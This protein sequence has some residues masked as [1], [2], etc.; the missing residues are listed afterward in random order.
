[1][2]NNLSAILDKAQVYSD[3]KKIEST[4]LLNSR[5]AA[6]QFNLTRQV[7]TTCD[8]A[9]AYASKLTEKQAP[10]NPDT[11]TTIAELK[12]RIQSTI[13]FLN[14]IKPEDFKGWESRKITNPR[15]EGKYLPANEYALQHAI[16]NFYFH[17]TT[18][19]SI[20]RHNGIEIGKK[21][22]LGEINYRPL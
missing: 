8:M 10:V 7:Q 18:A 20:L 4:V 19:Y 11:E 17:M 22:Y 13:Q 9:K 1:M 5:L 21:D 6:D 15:R 12:Q 16:P 2:L 3:Q 14:T